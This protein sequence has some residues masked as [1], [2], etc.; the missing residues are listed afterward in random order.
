MLPLS[1]RAR[2]LHCQL[3]RLH[4]A[5]KHS[6]VRGSPVGCGIFAFVKYQCHLDR[7]GQSDCFCVA[8]A[9][10]SCLIFVIRKKRQKKDWNSHLN[11]F[12][13][14]M[15][16]YAFL[17]PSKSYKKACVTLQLNTTSTAFTVF[18]YKVYKCNCEPLQ[19]FAAIIVSQA[20][21]VLSALPFW[22]I[23]KV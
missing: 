18:L 19:L 4:S 1:N 16:P 22:S 21:W 14:D 12:K 6:S 10:L 17:Q 2:V 7:A 9:L 13:K 23:Q 11:S 15:Q 8:L 5:C 3:C 20:L